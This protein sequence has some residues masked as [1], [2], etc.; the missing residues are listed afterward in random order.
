MDLTATVASATL[1]DN[2]IFGGRPPGR[3]LLSVSGDVNQGREMKVLACKLD[4]LDFA[5]AAVDG[6]GDDG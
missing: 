3:P 2:L 5:V 6:V 1:G 4:A